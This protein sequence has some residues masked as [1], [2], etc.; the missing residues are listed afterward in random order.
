V[1]HAAGTAQSRPSLAATLRP[2]NEHGTDRRQ[3]LGYGAVR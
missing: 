1:H 3:A 2:F